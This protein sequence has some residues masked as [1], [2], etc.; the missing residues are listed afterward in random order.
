IQTAT[1]TREQSGEVTKLR[2]LVGDND[3][4]HPLDEV[5]RLLTK[6]ALLR[7]YLHLLRRNVGMDGKLTLRPL[8][9]G[10]FERQDETAGIAP[11]GERLQ[12]RVEEPALA[13]RRA[14]GDAEHTS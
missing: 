2:G 8:G 9:P 3:V 7:P 13:D 1:R 5:A 6:N 4:P 12:D 10:H 14:R 11:R